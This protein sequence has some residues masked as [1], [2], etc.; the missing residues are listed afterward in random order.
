MESYKKD[1]VYQHGCLANLAF[2]KVKE[3]LGGRV[4]AIITGSAPIKAEV[5]DFLKIVTGAVIL[6]G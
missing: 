1:G 4:K 2:N 6:E 5:L 3:T